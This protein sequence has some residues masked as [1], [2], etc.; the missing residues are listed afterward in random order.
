MRVTSPRAARYA[1]MLVGWALSWVGFRSVLGRF[2]PV[3]GDYLATCGLGAP[4]VLVAA[5]APLESRWRL[6]GHEWTTE[7]LVSLAFG[8]VCYFPALLAVLGAAWIART[9]FGMD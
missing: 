3:A 9:L 4:I 6:S 5:F 2:D 1:Y 7:L 8:L